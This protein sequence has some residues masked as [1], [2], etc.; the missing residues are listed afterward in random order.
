LKTFSLILRL[1]KTIMN[2]QTTTIFRFDFTKDFL[3]SL[4]QFHHTYSSLNLAHFKQNWAQWKDDNASLLLEEEA[5][6]KALGFSS[7][8]DAKLLHCVRSYIPKKLGK[9]EKEKNE[10]KEKREKEKKEVKEVKPHQIPKE[11]LAE[12]DNFIHSHLSFGKKPLE[13]FQLFCS[14]NDNS[15]SHLTLKKTFQNRYQKIK[16]NT[17][18]PENQYENNTSQTP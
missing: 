2:T 14:R 8:F 6:L 4:I 16:S 3:Q 5:R 7:D 15:L 9:G 11:V 10:K 18:Q 13:L 1:K 17:K 12:M